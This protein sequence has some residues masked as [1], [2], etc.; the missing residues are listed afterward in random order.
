MKA[1]AWSAAKLW[2]AARTLSHS[3]ERLENLY[4]VAG[5][6]SMQRTVADSA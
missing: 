1:E 3:Q 2:S 4:M 6:G 5:P